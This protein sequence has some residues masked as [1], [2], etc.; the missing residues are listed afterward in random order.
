MAD[1]ER[2]ELDAYKKLISMGKERGYVTYDDLNE[3]L[4][5]ELVNNKLEQ[6]ISLFDE[7]EIEVLQK[8][9]ASGEEDKMDKDF[10]EESCFV[11]LMDI[12]NG[13]S[14]DP[15]KLY[16]KE[17]GSVP[18]L[19]KE[20]ETAI[21]KVIEE[22]EKE[23]LEALLD[24]GIA[25]KEIIKIGNR[26][27]RNEIDIRHVIRDLDE[28]EISEEDIAG[29]KQE[30][31]NLFDKIAVLHKEA[32]VLKQVSGHKKLSEMD[33]KTLEKKL[34]Q[35][36]QKMCECLQEI[37][38]NKKQINRIVDIIKKVM[39][40]V[41]SYEQCIGACVLK[42][43]LPL[44]KL[45]EKMEFLKKYPQRAEEIAQELNLSLEELEDIEERLK[46]GVRGISHIEGQTNSSIKILR[47]VLNRIKE[48]EKKA[49]EA[50]KKLVEANLRLVVSIAKRYTNR[51][52][53]FLDLI[54]EGNI[55]LM[56]AVEKFDYRRGYKFS[57]YAT[58]WIRQ[59]ITR[60]IADQARTIRI[61][62]HM[63]ETMN[64]LIRVTRLLI[65]EKGREPTPEE[66]AEKMDFPVEKVNKILR[67]TKE[68]ISLETPVGDDEDSVLSDFLEDKKNL[69][70]EEAAIKMDLAQQTRKVLSTLT[71]REEKV[72]RMRFGIGEQAD[73]TLEEVGRI[74][75]VTRERIR[76]I[77]AKALR[78]MRHPSRSKHLKSFLD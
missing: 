8:A 43:G 29:K 49:Q 71:P 40:K 70:P 56:R 2:N 11:P 69:P 77:E 62:V 75:S 73:H 25:V 72:L 36:K 26:L 10:K 20:E 68:P 19:T 34:A 52:L 63:I 38:L 39:T 5:E 14:V 18:L 30:V 16:L 31:I 47:D 27:K 76:Q 65:Q 45:K 64:K 28:E 57:T 66:I 22:G 33:R 67:I 44:N 15:V 23:V 41:E 50:K 21:A 24:S 74:F 3:I 60:A 1:E 9:P 61:P 6:V 51:G 32:S 4:P 42:T 53:H 55:G 7:M 54:Q 13:R 78:K 17:M 35:N 48:G 58:W 46:K 59:A 12:T 37:R